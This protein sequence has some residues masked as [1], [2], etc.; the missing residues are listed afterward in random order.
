MS[1][2]TAA[3]FASKEIVFR[4]INQLISLRITNKK[5]TPARI[6]GVSLEVGS[7]L[8]WWPNW[9]L[10]CPVE[11]RG[12]KLMIAPSGIDNAALVADDTVLENVLADK[13]IASADSAVGWMAW[14]CPKS[15]KCD[16]KELRIGVADSAGVV[17]WQVISD[18]PIALNLFG[19]SLQIGP[20]IDLRGQ[21]F[22]KQSACPSE[23]K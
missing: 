22:K 4:P 3:W 20:P 10:L 8:W 19:S 6:T 12:A 13:P 14:E 9:T 17:S 21:S 1:I 15:R 16:S 23:R 7:D 5:N 18:P 2:F 11:L